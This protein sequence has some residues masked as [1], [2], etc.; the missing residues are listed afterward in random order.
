VILSIAELIVFSVIGLFLAFYTTY[1]LI[2]LR[3]YKLDKPTPSFSFREDRLPKVSFI[4][5]IYNE[6]KVIESRVENFKQIVYPPRKLEIVFVDGGSN[7][8]TL[9]KLKTLG[10]NVDFSLRILEQGIRKGFNSA[11]VEGFYETTGDIIFITGAETKFEPNAIRLIVDHFANPAV[12][13]V[14]GTMRLSNE[15]VASSTKIEAGYR[16][17]YDFLRAAEGKM[18][19][20]FDIKGEIAATRRII[21]EKLV[22]NCELFRKGCIDCCFVFQAKKDGY[23]TIFEPKAIYYEPAP[24]AI[25]DSFKQQS[26]RAATLIENMLVFKD[27]IL[28]PKYGKFGMI[29][30]PAHFF[31]LIVLPLLF[32]FS[33]VSIPLLLMFYSYNYWLWALIILVIGAF[34]FSYKVKAFFKAQISLI[35]AIFKMLK[36]TETQ[37]F[38][39]LSSIRP[40]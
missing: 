3:Y 25:Q 15:K 10:S 6:V 8:G 31:M 37:K 32:L 27:L 29:I 13:A 33:V 5:P 4:I 9:E 35:I 20:P 23:A 12:G 34:F 28:R 7:D 16:S 36:G 21:C 24:T 17:F 1:F 22:N 18:D 40:K 19:S 38:E 39:R 14:N 26:R 11:V 2:C 30:M